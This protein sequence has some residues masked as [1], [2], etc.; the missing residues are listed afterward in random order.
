MDLSPVN[1]IFVPDKLTFVLFVAITPFAFISVLFISPAN[2]LTFVL[3]VAT[4]PFPLLISIV[5]ELV[6]VEDDFAYSPTFFDS[7]VPVAAFT[8]FAPSANAP[9]LFAGVAVCSDVNFPEFLNS[10]PSFV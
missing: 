10:A 6:T 1:L 4:I 3:S 8:N 2:K 9:I 7:I 5:P